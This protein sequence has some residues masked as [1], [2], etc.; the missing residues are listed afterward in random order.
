VE[1]DSARHTCRE[2][3]EKIESLTAQLQ[4]P[5]SL[6]RSAVAK[7]QIRAMELEINQHTDRTDQWKHR[8]KDAQ[9]ETTRVARES[10]GLQQQIDSWRHD[11][12][13]LKDTEAIL[14]QQITQ[15]LKGAETSTEKIRGL[16][17]SI[18][19]KDNVISKL[20]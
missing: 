10:E 3:Q 9:T 7:T 15:L 1:L 17:A 19:E 20:Q 16:E 14:N 5:K 12:D 6:D 13:K 8:I 2:R 18:S 11:Y 4:A